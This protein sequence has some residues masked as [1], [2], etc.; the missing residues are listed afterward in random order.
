[1]HNKPMAAVHP[2]HRLRALIQ[3]KKKKKK[4]CAIRF[5]PPGGSGG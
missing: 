4:T 1:L 2:E 3:K 5:L